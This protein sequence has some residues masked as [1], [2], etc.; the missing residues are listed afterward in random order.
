MEPPHSGLTHTIIGCLYETANE[1]GPGYSE[2]VHTRALQVVLIE[3]GLKAEID[4]PIRVFFRGKLV[5]RFW[6]DMI[7]NDTVLLEIK[8]KPEL[9]PKDVAQILNYLTCVGGGIGL[10]VNF[11]ASVTFQRFAKGDITNCLPKLRDEQRQRPA[12]VAAERVAVL[13]GKTRSADLYRDRVFLGNA[14]QPPTREAR[15]LP[16][17]P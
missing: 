15:P 17:S 4:V 5:G 14:A 9:E 13:P 11:G 12:A 6:A 7:V 10:L 2:R 16:S 1:L 3:K 8:K